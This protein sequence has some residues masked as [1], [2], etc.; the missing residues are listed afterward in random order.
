[1]TTREPLEKDLKRKIDQATTHETLEKDLKRKFD[2]VNLDEANL[3][4]LE[5]EEIQLEEYLDNVN[6]STEEEEEK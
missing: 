1:M 2:Q 5:D 6:P 4:A 3:R